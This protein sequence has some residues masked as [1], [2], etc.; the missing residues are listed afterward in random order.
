MMEQQTSWRGQTF[1]LVIF[2]GIVVLCSIFFVLGMLVGRTQGLKLA[3]IATAE[4]ATKPE[5][6]DPAAKDRPE[7][8]FFEAVEKNKPAP[9]ETLPAKPAAPAP[10]PPKVEAPPPV[11]EVV[12]IQVAA[13]PKADSAEKIV[14]KLRAQGFRAFSVAPAPDDPKPFYRVQ[15]ADPNGVEA[16]SLKR[17]LVGAG[18]KDAMIRK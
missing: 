12:T 8:T 4:A 7:H 16:E 15:L 14:E 3:T 13:L 17:K 9:L 2:G 10:A 18:Y 6:A 1:T 11:V 5:A